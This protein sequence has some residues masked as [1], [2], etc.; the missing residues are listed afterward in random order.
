MAWQVEVDGRRC[1]AS[2]MCAGMAPELF[3]L[4]GEHARPVHGEIDPGKVGGTV[5]DA[6]DSCPA[7]AIT[8]RDAEKVIG[9]RP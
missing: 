2:G 8:V 4:A 9:P 3:V 6:A 5:L 1:M 7:G